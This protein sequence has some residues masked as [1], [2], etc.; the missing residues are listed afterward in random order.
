[1]TAMS[2]DLGYSLSVVKFLPM[3]KKIFWLLFTVL[4]VVMGL[5]LPSLW[6]NLAL[7]LPLLVLCWWVV[8]RSGWFN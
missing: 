4:G 5:V 8:Y 6:W 7:T 3:E 2:R 1:M